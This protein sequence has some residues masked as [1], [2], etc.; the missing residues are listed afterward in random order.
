MEEQLKSSA[1]ARNGRWWTAGLS[2]AVT[3]GQPVPV[4]CG[5]VPLVLFRD[6]QGMARALLDECAHRRAPLSLGT[7]DSQGIIQCP[8]HG[9]RYE[10][11]SGQCVAIPNL[12]AS[13]KVP[14]AYRVPA[15]AV[16][17][18]D[19]FIH[20]WSERD[21]TPDRAVASLELPSLGNERS[22]VSLIAYPHQSTVDLLLDAPG[23]VLDISGITIINAH[24]F[25]D[26]VR[27]DG[28][29]SVDYAAVRGS[30][31]PRQLVSE[32]PFRVSLKV[33][34]DGG[35]A[36]VTV[37]DDS[38]RAHATAVMGLIPVRGTLC[39]ISLRASHVAAPEGAR[40]TMIGVRQAFDAA[41]LRDTVDY[42]SRLR[43]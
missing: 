41:T 37:A 21:A 43:R 31:P 15:F 34:I 23:A 28:M 20:V 25:G 30:K 38:G 33:A 12:S 14:R 11:A 22:H 3:T 35:H 39:E 26:P 40:P 27:A 8:Y 16:E 4:K 29:I 7:V 36:R 18:Q 13:E 6:A 5:D 17:E 2:G 10:G 1:T 42:V 32:Y 19:G 24:R 9:W